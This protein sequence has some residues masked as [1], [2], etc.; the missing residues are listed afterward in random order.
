[1]KIKYPCHKCGKQFTE[2]GS[3]KKHIQSV[4][5]RVM[6]PCDKTR[7]L[8][9]KISS[10]ILIIVENN[11]QNKL[12]LKHIFSLFMKVSSILVICVII[13][14]QQWVVFRNILS[15][16]MKVSSILVINVINNLQ[17]KVISRNIFKH[18][19]CRPPWL[20]VKCSFCLNLLSFECIL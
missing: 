12:I 16:N 5:E 19:M 17:G 11:L 3:M 9:M 4:H 1:M 6:F 20:R 2:L 10:I 7:C 14:L 18:I 13:K 8:S 15:L